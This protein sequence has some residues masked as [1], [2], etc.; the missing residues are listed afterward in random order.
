MVVI[1]ETVFLSMNGNL[2]HYF[3][4]GEDLTKIYYINIIPID[5]V[6][7]INSFINTRLVVKLIVIYDCFTEIMCYIIRAYNRN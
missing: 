6:T 3:P 5:N 4:F 1:A 2:N 7:E